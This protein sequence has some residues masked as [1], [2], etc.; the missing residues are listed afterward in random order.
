MVGAYPSRQLKHPRPIVWAT[1]RSIYQRKRH[2]F[3]VLFPHLLDRRIDRNSPLDR[4]DASTCNLGMRPAQD[5]GGRLERSV[6]IRQPVTQLRQGF[7]LVCI[8][9][10]QTRHGP[11]RK[12]SL[13]F[14]GGKV[15][16]R[17]VRSVIAF[18]SIREKITCLL[19]RTDLKLNPGLPYAIV[20]Q[21]IWLLDAEY[22]AY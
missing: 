2:V 14:E 7:R 11:A 4:V 13:V 20:T 16:R 5:L 6:P 17:P 19:N 8:P 9:F 22:L 18:D 21:V 1:A 3:S 10:T 15:Y 12:P